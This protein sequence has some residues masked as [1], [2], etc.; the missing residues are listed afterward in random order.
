MQR[1]CARAVS[2]IG[3]NNVAK[4]LAETLIEEEKTDKL[5]TTRLRQ[6]ERSSREQ[7]KRIGSVNDIWFAT[8]LSGSFLGQQAGD[9][10]LP[11]LERCELRDINV[12]HTNAVP[13]FGIPRLGNEFLYRIKPDALAAAF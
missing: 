6:L 1:F 8:L 9:A 4:L 11:Q 2:Q 13:V 3:Q 10:L 7:V 5:L 12:D